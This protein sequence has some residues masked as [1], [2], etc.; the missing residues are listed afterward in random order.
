MIETS[1]KW[2]A[3]FIVGVILQSTVIPVIA[4]F[5]VQPD[6]PV[7]VLFFMCLRHGVLPGVYIGFFLGLGLDLYS[8]TL[9]GQ[10]ALA[11][12]IIGFFIGLFNEKVMRTDPVLKVVILTLTFL[13]HDAVFAGTELIK[14]GSSIMR[15]FPELLL[16]TLPRT[17]YS[18]VVIFLIH[19]WNNTILPNLRR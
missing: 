16:Y 9:L 2:A 15:I 18:I 1:I 5:G 4:I 10:Q 19:L 8:P 14:H 3:A 6:L 13:I 11:K 7:I 17:I 12:T